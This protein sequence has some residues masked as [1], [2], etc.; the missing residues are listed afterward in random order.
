MLVNKTMG[1]SNNENRFL[2]YVRN[3]LKKRGCPSFFIPNCNFKKS[4]IL[5][6]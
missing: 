6:M 4:D 5:K 1:H 2:L 3:R